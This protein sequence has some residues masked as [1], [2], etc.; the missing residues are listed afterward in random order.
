MQIVPEGPTYEVAHLG[1]PTEAIGI[2]GPGLGLVPYLDVVATIDN[3][4]KSAAL[5][6]LNRD[7]EKPREVEISWRDIV[8]SKINTCQTMTGN[9]LKAVNTFERPTN[10]VP[11]NLESPRL[12]PKMTL[13]VP[14]R[15]YSVVS[16]AI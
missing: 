5:F 13:Q 8:P 4:S 11:Q 3:E 6:I 2:I 7:L 10:V 9:D 1:R 15:S 16:L 12:G 14:A